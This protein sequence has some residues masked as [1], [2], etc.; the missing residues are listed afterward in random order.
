MANKPI[1]MLRIRQLIQFLERGVSLR[2]ISSEL[3]M[4]RNIV[5]TYT[6]RIGA[7]GHSCQ[8][9]LSLD[10]ASLSALLSGSVA[11]ENIPDE[12][13]LILEPFLSGYAKELKRTGVT[14]LLLWEEYRADYPGGYGYT[15]FKHHLNRHI[16]GR[17]YAFHHQHVPGR[18]MQVDFAGDS[19]YL[20]DKRTGEQRAAPVLVCTLPCSGQT[21]AVA[22]RDTRQESFYYGMNKCLEYFGGVPESVKSD[23]M[24]QWVKRADRYEPTFNDATLQWAV[25]YQTCLM[26]ARAL[27]PTDKG[28]VEGHVNIVYRRIHARLR[29][30]AFHTLDA[31]NS[32][33]LELLEEHNH[34]PMQGRSYSRYEQ[35]TSEEKHLLKPLPAD[36]FLFKYR[37]DFTV[38]STYHVQ[39]SQDGHFYSIPH[40]W[41]G[42]KA[43]VV[44]DYENVEIYVSMERVAYHRRSFLKGGYS[45]IEAHMPEHHRAYRRSQEYNAEYY[46]RQALHIGP[47]TREA[48]SRILL[49]KIF[50]Q[51]SYRSCMGII[52][53]TR[54][55]PALRVEAA[56]S[57]AC[58]SPSVCYTMI[59]HILE[60]K[61]D[62]M[63]PTNDSLHNLPE[64]DN[65]RGASAY[66]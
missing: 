49:S 47:C 54:K 17:K 50:I 48:V 13:F 60:K 16:K 20:T 23:N 65:I 42:C 11:K 59:K 66:H 1:S 18:E 7:S 44:Y 26:A 21:F 64:H 2:K 41:V 5:S 39:I 33:V 57:R 30:E 61:L 32:R 55:Y 52:S 24:R 29:D 9:L 37:K 28:H 27:K 56:C 14:K 53:L 31:L 12:R 45:T 62:G 36:A 19:L 4:G 6:E 43:V 58:Q 63:P 8:E 46:L 35:F 22:L 38:N 15:Q 3:R 40:R 25:H 34:K 10:D 51:Q